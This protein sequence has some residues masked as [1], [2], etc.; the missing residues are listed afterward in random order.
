MNQKIRGRVIQQNQNEWVIANEQDRVRVPISASSQ[1]IQVG[2]LIE[3]NPEGSC[4]RLLTQNTTV[5][6]T[7]RWTETIL[8]PR[9]RQAMKIR[10]Q[11][12]AEIRNFFLFQ[13]FLETRTPLLVRCPG[14]EPHIHPFQIEKSQH[15]DHRWYLPTSPEFAM[16]RLLVGG[17]EKIFQICPAFRDEPASRMHQAEFTL[18][19]WYRAYA[20]EEEIMRDVEC[21]FEALAQKLWGRS[22][23]FFQGQKISVQSPWPRLTVRDLF[24]E[25][26][27]FDLAGKS[28]VCDIQKECGRLGLHWNPEETWD[29]LYFKI[30]LNEIEPR[31]PADQA[32]FVIRYPVSQAALAQVEQ[33]EDGFSW[34]RRFEVYAGRFEL[35]NA[36]Q[37]LT[38][39]V[40]QKRRFLKDMQLR[41]ETYGA[42]VPQSDMDE[43]FLE[44]L[45]EGMPP[46]GGIAMGVDRMVMLF[47]DEPE[48]EWTRWL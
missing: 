12:E 39:A 4:L 11:M 6:R 19:E 23:L 2:D 10:E 3:T 21:L 47:A 17:L 26:A 43:E 20:S 15:S 40:E 36:F 1:G 24:R 45:H 13:G 41:K 37:E 22:F 48:I 30:W 44:A 25:Y 38:D 27:G 16:K 7:F 31:L 32:V 28:R 34:A 8:H 33:D 9:R 29:D 42:S 46:S 14:M 5:E 18:L 35:G